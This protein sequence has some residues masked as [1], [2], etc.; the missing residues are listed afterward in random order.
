MIKMELKLEN[1]LN[2]MNNLGYLYIFNIVNLK[3]YI[4]ENIK[5]DSNLENG[6]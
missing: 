5:K 6:I 1:G 3:W 2:F 4:L